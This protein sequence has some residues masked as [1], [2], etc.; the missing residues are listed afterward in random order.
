MFLN[1]HCSG[2]L[3]KISY[4]LLESNTSDMCQRHI[5]LPSLRCLARGSSEQIFMHA[6]SHLLTCSWTCHG[7]CGCSFNLLYTNSLLSLQYL[8]LQKYLLYQKCKYCNWIE[9]SMQRILIIYWAVTLPTLCAYSTSLCAYFYT[10]HCTNMMFNSL[11][12]S[13]CHYYILPIYLD[14]SYG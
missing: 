9:D 1:L 6:L 12:H 8:S 13:Q 11:K 10:K 2:R 5:A 4:C 7:L 14:F 3:Y